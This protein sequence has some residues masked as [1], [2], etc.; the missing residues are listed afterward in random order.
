M[1]RT[2]IAL[3]ALAFMGAIGGAV[4]STYAVSAPANL[5]VKDPLTNQCLEQP[6]C[7]DTG[8][9]PCTQSFGYETFAKCLTDL[10]ADRIP[11]FAPVP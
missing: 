4:A 5:Y 3:T 1:K 10:E 11:A 9:D 7:A 2:K 6:T 8:I